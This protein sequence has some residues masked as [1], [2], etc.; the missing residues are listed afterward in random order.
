[1]GKTG[2]RFFTA[3]NAEPAEIKKGKSTNILD[4]DFA[5]GGGGGLVRPVEKPQGERQAHGPSPSEL[6]EAGESRTG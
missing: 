6:V 1:M 2:K 3:E 4:A 5:G